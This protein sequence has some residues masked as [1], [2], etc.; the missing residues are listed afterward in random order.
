MHILVIMDPL[1]KLD[2]PKDTSV[3]F[4]LAALNRGWSVSV[5]TIGDLYSLHNQVCAHAHS[6][7][8]DPERVLV[9]T[10]VKLG[11]LADFDAA[12]LR[13]DPPEPSA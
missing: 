7:E 11:P 8:Q 13:V 2:L 12:L 5:C 1:E 4:I 10:G 6:V 3:G 9:V